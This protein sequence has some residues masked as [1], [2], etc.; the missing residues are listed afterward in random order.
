[1]RTAQAFHIYLSGRLEHP[2][3]KGALAGL[4]LEAQP[5]EDPAAIIRPALILVAPGGAVPDGLAEIAVAP[6]AGAP[7]GA[8]RELL[9]VAMENVALKQQ[10]KV[11][12]DQAGRQHRQFAELNRIGIALSAE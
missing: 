7:P 12:E 3:L 9:R 6:P 5:L 10:V 11:H 8:L 2:G 4:G 1:M